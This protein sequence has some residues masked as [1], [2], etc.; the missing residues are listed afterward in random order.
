M[1]DPNLFAVW[2]G[3]LR[4]LGGKHESVST[5]SEP[6]ER[7]GRRDPDNKPRQYEL[8]NERYGMDPNTGSIRRRF[9]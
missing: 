4:D 1:K 9:Q 3:W 2:L 5:A 6:K 8:D 7:T